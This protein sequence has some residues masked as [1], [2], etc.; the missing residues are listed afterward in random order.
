MQG[1]ALQ[2]REQGKASCAGGGGVGN[3]GSTGPFTCREGLVGAAVPSVLC[4][5]DAAR[6]ACSGGWS[7]RA[8]F[9][10]GPQAVLTDRADPLVAPRDA[11]FVRAAVRDECK[12]V[13]KEYDKTE[14]DLTA[15]QS[16][17]QIIGEV[18]KQLDDER[19][20]VK[21]SSGP[22]YVVGCRN[23]VDKALLKP[24]ARVALDMTTLTIMRLLPREVRRS[25]AANTAAD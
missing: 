14:D 13:D 8:I 16:V 3:G 6:A 21:A 10:Y 9:L 25:P 18:L 1:E 12:K 19:F 15:L 17:G 7:C 4:A 20:I 23:K 24:T 22:R 5:C 11:A 2:S